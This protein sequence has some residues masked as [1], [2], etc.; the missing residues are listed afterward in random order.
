MEFALLAVSKPFPSPKRKTVAFQDWERVCRLGAAV[1]E[2]IGLCVKQ[3]DEFFP[4]LEENLV[5][6][7]LMDRRRIVF[8][9]R[10]GENPSAPR[11]ELAGAIARTY[12]RLK[13]E[14]TLYD[15]LRASVRGDKAATRAVLVGMGR[16]R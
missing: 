2:A 8:V 7:V 12:K 13:A 15:M 6:H 11:T 9:V 16:M 10:N 14:K 4:A 5:R 3:A 1:A